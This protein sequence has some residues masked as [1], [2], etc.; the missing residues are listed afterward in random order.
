MAPPI[1]VLEVTLVDVP[2]EPVVGPE[3]AV[4]PPDPTSEKSSIEHAAKETSGSE[5]RSTA[6]RIF[7]VP[8]RTEASSG[9]DSRLVASVGASAGDRALRLWWYDRAH[10]DHGA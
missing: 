3:V 8:K 6:A 2:S 10:D 1:P 9:I 4:N 5:L 7:T